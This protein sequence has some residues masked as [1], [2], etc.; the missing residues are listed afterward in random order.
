VRAAAVSPANE[1]TWA[2]G[3]YD[4]VV[5]LWDVRVKGKAGG[6]MSMDHGAPVEDVAWFPSGEPA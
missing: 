2:T 1:E 5:K 6:L 3:G 4:H